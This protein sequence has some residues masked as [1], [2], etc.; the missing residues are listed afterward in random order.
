MSALLNIMLNNVVFKQT[1]EM[2]IIDYNVGYC[3]IGIMC[4][5][6]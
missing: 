1:F 3:P 5:T 2:I 4:S 6:A